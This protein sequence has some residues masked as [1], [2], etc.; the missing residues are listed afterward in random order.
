[1]TPPRRHTPASSSPSPEPVSEP[2]SAPPSL[3]RRGL[4]GVP[5]LAA[6]AA[7][8]LPAAL[9]TPAAR[10]AAT[11]FTVYLGA[12]TGPDPTHGIGVA[13]ADGTTGALTLD[14]VTPTANPSF[15]ALGP[16]ADVLYAVNENGEGRVSAFAL[17]ADG[18]VTGSLGSAPTGGGAPCHLVVHAD[19]GHLFVA[20]Y[21][22]GSVAVVTLGGDGT[23]L[24]VSHLVQHTGS[25]PDP[26][27]QEGPHAHMVLTDP[28]APNR[29]LAVDLGTDSVY[30]YAFDPGTGRLTQEHQVAMAPGSGPR[31]LA[32]HP[33]GDAAYVLG[34][35]NSTLTACAYDAATGG[36]TP[37]GVVPT[38]PEGAPAD[39]NTPAEVLVSSDGR[40][41]YASNRGHDS[42]A[43]LAVAEGDHTALTPLG[44]H[45]CGG[46]GPRHL[47]LSPDESWLYAANQYS[48][49]V[50]RLARDATTGAL[51]PSG[52]PL[53]YSQVVCALPAVPPA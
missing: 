26:D 10:A 44:H 20:N 34:E 53:P 3:R 14:A 23:P 50:T 51:A 5:L 4:L 37:G 21:S 35:L 18:N 47:A 45:P 42:V 32:L 13:R 19:G 48:G 2:S 40:F 36:L 29:L 1:M 46:S 6:T 7:V 33:A 52:E 49:T 27:R 31:H 12:Y 15:L 8:A 17:G 38:L 25:G 43:V 9:A 39:G 24:E 41:V 11:P 30:V 16:G 22:S 28:A